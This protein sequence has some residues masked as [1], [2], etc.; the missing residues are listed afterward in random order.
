MLLA[1]PTTDPALGVT[2]YPV[3]AFAAVGV[4]L[5]AHVDALTDK[6]AGRVAETVQDV[7]VAPLRLGVMVVIADPTVP[8]YGP[9]KVALGAST[10]A[11]VKVVC[12]VPK[13]FVA[14]TV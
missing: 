11:R 8:V 4:P 9:A 12:E 13:I 6:P 5:I 10:I 14:V 7:G 3:D 1:D 2:A